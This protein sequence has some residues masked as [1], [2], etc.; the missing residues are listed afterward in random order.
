MIFLVLPHVA[1]FVAGLT[2]SWLYLLRKW[3]RYIA[4]HPKPRVR[5]RRIENPDGSYIRIIGDDPDD[6]TQDRIQR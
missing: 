4:A 2:I 1:A 5:F 6:D 3:D